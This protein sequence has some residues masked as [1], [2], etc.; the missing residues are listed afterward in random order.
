MCKQQTRNRHIE[1]FIHKYNDKRPDRGQTKCKEIGVH[2]H[3]KAD[4]HT[5]KHKHSQNTY[6]GTQSH[7]L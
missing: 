7:M 3:S 6:N 1:K 2:I 5:Y 4:T